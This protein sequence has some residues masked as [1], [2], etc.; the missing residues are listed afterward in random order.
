M[1]SIITFLFSTREG[2]AILFFGGIV[3]IAI[4]AFIMEKRT[5]KLYVDRGEAPQDDE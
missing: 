3:I 4:V 1:D 2:L 5:A